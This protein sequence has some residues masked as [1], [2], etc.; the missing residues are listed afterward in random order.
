MQLLKNTIALFLLAVLCVQCTSESGQRVDLVTERPTEGLITTVVEVAPEDW[1]IEDE[2]VVPD[3]ADS[4]II[5][6]Y[7]NG[8]IDTF[9][10][11][12]AKLMTDNNANRQG[13]SIAQV[14]GY[15]LMGY[16]LFGRSM[17]SYR[18]RSSAYVNQS[19]YNRVNQNAG[20]RLNS[21][22]RRTTTSRPRTGN[23]GYGG[24]RSTRS[25]GG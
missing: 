2:V 19:T 1:K 9:T 17:G 14:A 3:P 15:G 11:E 18:P 21:T 7:Q 16:W 5:A 12:Q 22:A 24:N 10:L 20:Q 13:M 8:A 23:S 25:V 6:K 4:R